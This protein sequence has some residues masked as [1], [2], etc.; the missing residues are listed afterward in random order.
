MQL[1]RRIV[2]LS[3]IVSIDLIKC[4]VYQ[5]V[6]YKKIL[7]SKNSIIK[8]SKLRENTPDLHHY[9]VHKQQYPYLSVILKCSISSPNTWF[10]FKSIYISIF[11]YIIK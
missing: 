7:S 9:G 1:E 8:L 5:H 11:K 2:D 10:I 3:G 4:N 6:L